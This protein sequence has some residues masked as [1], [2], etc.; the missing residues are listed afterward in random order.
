MYAF[1]YHRRRVAKQGASFGGRQGF[2]I[3]ILLFHIALNHKVEGPR[4]LEA[5]GASRDCGL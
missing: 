3:Y 4:P 5:P 2:F 1:E